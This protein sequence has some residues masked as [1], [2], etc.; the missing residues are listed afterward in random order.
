MLYTKYTKKID[1]MLQANWFFSLVL[2]FQSQ[3]SWATNVKQLLFFLAVS[4]SN[5]RFFV[6]GVLYLLLC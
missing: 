1:D 5:C 4:F 3:M 2:I 6:A